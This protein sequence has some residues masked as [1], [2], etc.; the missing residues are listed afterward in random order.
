MKKWKK[1]TLIGCSTCLVLAVLGSIVGL[2][3]LRHAAKSFVASTESFDESQEPW[4]E[5][6]VPHPG[7]IPA[8]MFM[9]K[10][11]HPFL[12]EYEYK[13]RFGDETNPIERWLPLNCGGRTRMNA[14]WY[15]ADE[16]NGPCIRLQDHWGEYLLRLKEAKTYLILR[17]KGRILAGEISESSPASSMG[18][19]DHAGG[20]AEI[21]ASVGDNTAIDITDTVVGRESGRYF[22]RIDGREYPVRF[23]P[24]S[25]SPEIEIEMR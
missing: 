3:F 22:G 17:Y 1:I 15:P 13:V 12:A 6:C 25:E 8:L 4:T 2:L 10:S 16:M 5:C 19:R 11:I 7:D 9:Q 14:Y 21:Y 20:K 23:I 18:A 24:V